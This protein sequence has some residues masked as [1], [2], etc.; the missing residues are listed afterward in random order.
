[1]LKTSL[2]LIASLFSLSLPTSASEDPRV[3]E[4]VDLNRYKGLW[5]EIAHSPNFFQRRCERSTAE[6][7]LLP[8][9]KISVLNTCYR[10][11]K[12][13]SSIEG[14]AWA[15]NPEQPAKLVV[16]FGFFRKGDYWITML[17]PDYQWA[18]VS[19]PAKSSIFILARQ[20]PMDP[21]LLESII[22]QMRADGYNVG[23]LIYD[24]Y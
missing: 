10:D 3:V 15:P 13:L 24:R 7:G 6:Y 12:P 23:D 18:V 21:V 4:N 9:G 5:Y 17:D 14:T 11:E 19:G 8:E 16:D 20:A 1:M 22:E 2:L